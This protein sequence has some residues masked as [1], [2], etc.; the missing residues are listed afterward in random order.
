MYYVFLIFIFDILI[1]TYL[2]FN[3]LGFFFYIILSDIFSSLLFTLN[4]I[5]TYKMY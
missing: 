4:H 5:E 2:I 1:S 3:L